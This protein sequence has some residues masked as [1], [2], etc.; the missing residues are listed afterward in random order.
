M[1]IK[2]HNLGF[3]RIGARRELKFALERYWRGEIDLE[4]LETIASGLRKL[5]WRLQAD[6]GLDYLPVGDSSF[7]DHVLDTSVLLGAFPERFGQS[8][9]QV[10]MDLYF[11]M[12]RGRSA[13]GKS[14]RACEMTKWFNTNYH[15]IVPELDS[16]LSFRAACDRLFHWVDE[17]HALGHKVKPVVLGPLTWL[18]LGKSADRDF[19]RLDLLDGMIPVYQRILTRLAGLGVEW[20]QIDEPALVLDLPIAWQNAY[21]RVY[22]AL[23]RSPVKL[24]LTTYFGALGDNVSLACRLPVAGIHIDLACAPDQWLPVVDRL[25][26]YK[27]LSLG[28][29]DGRNIWRSDLA[30]KL[31]VVRSVRSRYQGELW[32]APSCSLLHVPM[33]LEPETSLAAEIRPWLAF[34]RQKLGELQI[35]GRALT[36]GEEVVGP[37][38]A[39]SALAVQQRRISERLNDKAV[40]TRVETIAAEDLHR[41]TPREQRLRLQ[42]ESLGLPLYP[43]TTIGSFPQTDAIREARRKYRQGMIKKS[44]YKQLMKEAIAHAIQVQ[45][46]CGLDVFVHGEPERNDMV[47]YFAEQL[48]GV[49]T[50]QNGWVQ[51]YGSRCVK[52]P[53]VFGDVARPRAM[54]LEWIEY[55]QSLTDRPVKAMLTGPVTL[56]NWAFVRDD[57]P[58]RTTALQLALA[59]R[60]EVADLAASGIRIIQV[61]EAA[62]AEGLPLRKPEQEGYLNWATEAFRLATAVAGDQIQIHT[63]MCY[64]EFNGILQALAAMDADVMTLESCRSDMAL[65]DALAQCEYPGQIGPGVYDIHSPNLPDVESIIGRVE[66]ILEWI[67]PEKVWINP[68]CGLKTRQWTEVEPA[69][70]NLAEAAR[71]LRLSSGAVAVGPYRVSA[72]GP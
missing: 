18:W 38:L 17:A 31:D 59:L 30:V 46:R 34:A 25:A 52:P 63:H 14:A 20:V 56:L 8:S 21:E 51:S 29:I 70:Q 37:E 27:I 53:I 55:A 9:G 1:S 28:L 12:A 5:H 42:T 16:G 48:Q 24:L 54:T 64:S 36:E 3:P 44:R 23:Q 32:L 49:T 67:A 33:D 22:H 60:D 19:D 62:L 2:L 4:Q 58:R 68:D 69:L 13:D 10:D 15:Y 50:T 6:A 47:E 11:R 26:R 41:A 61:D 40:K 7:Y 66:K 43:V 45:K 57:Q 72:G 39:A 71:R 65:V 35:L